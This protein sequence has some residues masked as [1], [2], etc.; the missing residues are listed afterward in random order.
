VVCPTI[1]TIERTSFACGSLEKGG[2]RGLPYNLA[3][4]EN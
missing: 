3:D 2:K 4:R 1:R